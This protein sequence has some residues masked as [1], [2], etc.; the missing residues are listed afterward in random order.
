MTHRDSAQCLRTDP[1]TR[2]TMDLAR[3]RGLFR[4]SSTTCGIC[5]QRCPRRRSRGWP[6]WSA[7]FSTARR[8]CSQ[9]P[10]RPGRGG[11]RR[12]VP[13]RGDHLDEARGDLL[14][15]TAFPRE[16]CLHRGVAVDPRSGWLV[17][18]GVPQPHCAVQTGGGQQPPVGAECDREDA[19]VLANP[20]R[21]RSG[22][23]SRRVGGTESGGSLSARQGNS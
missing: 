2:P 20:A 1:H 9:G 17:R 16:I 10:V 15:F 18:G 19:A 13:G 22:A 12:E 6:P 8:R 14:A 5:C 7:R 3:L 23:V 21:R 4:Y 11:D